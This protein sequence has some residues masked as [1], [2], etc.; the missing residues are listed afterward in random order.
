MPSPSSS[1]RRPHTNGFSQPSCSM[2]GCW[3]CR[4]AGAAWEPWPLST[5]RSKGTADTCRK[6][7]LVG[8][9]GLEFAIIS[10]QPAVPDQVRWFSE[11]TG[12][13]LC[14]CPAS[15]TVEFYLCYLTSPVPFHSG[16]SLYFYTRCL[17]SPGQENYSVPS[18]I[19]AVSCVCFAPS[20]GSPSRVILFSSC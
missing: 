1:G 8:F 4:K 5:G 18:G 13:A 7:F 3:I 15:G 10:H 12:V 17:V 2:G 19:E 6:G 11:T 9:A 16:A 14:L 20:Q